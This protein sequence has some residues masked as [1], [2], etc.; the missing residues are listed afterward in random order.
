VKR[1]PGVN[2]ILA[3]T[4]MADIV[5]DSRGI[6]IMGDNLAVGRGTEGPNIDILCTIG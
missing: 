4:G 3:N 2:V 6:I 5:L 1:S